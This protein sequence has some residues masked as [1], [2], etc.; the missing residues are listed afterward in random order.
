MAMQ[1]NEY[2][3]L[4][5]SRLRVSPLGLG[6]MTFGNDSCGSEDNESRAIFD[7]YSKDVL[8]SRIHGDVA[9]HRW[10]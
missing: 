10:W 5:R 3:T 7:R 6:T 1:L 4:G 2:I 9:V 8:Q